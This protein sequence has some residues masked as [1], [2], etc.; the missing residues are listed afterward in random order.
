MNDYIT[1][2]QARL[3]DSYIEAV[4]LESQVNSQIDD[5]LIEKKKMIQ[6][7]NQSE[8]DDEIFTLNK[9]IQESSDK[10][11]KLEETLKI[12]NQIANNARYKM[13]AFKRLI[14]RM[15]LKYGDD[16]NEWST[17]DVAN[18]STII[19]KYNK[20]DF[21][22]YP[23]KKGDSS[24]HLGPLPEDGYFDGGKRRRSKQRQRTQI[25]SK[26]FSARCCTRRSRRI[27]CRRG[28]TA[29][30]RQNRSRCTELKM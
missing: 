14:Q 10:I 9:K 26:N 1:P 3:N 20:N 8:D 15:K 30:R 11:N 19:E 23:K 6:K 29:L 2:I 13:H 16:V 27:S 28:E 22:F 7:R 4:R 12:H 21:L 5:A 25:K 24:L 18:A 17:D